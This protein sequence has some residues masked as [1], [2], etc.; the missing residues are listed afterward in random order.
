MHSREFVDRRFDMKAMVRLLVESQTY[1]L[2]SEPTSENRNDQQNFARYY[3]RRLPAEVA[4]DA[5]EMVTGFRSTFSNMS[6]DARAVDLPHERFGS[7]FLD[8]FDRPNA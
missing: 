7:Y 6:T 1:Q 5:V 8:T 2:S 4:F 3:G